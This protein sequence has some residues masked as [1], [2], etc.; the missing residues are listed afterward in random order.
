[1]YNIC[2]TISIKIYTEIMN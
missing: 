2:I 1:M